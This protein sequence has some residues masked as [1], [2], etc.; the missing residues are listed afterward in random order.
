MRRKKH[1]LN[2]AGLVSIGFL[3]ILLT[4]ALLLMLPAS[5]GSGCWTNPLT[6]LFTATS[7]TCVTGLLL[8][9]NWIYWSFFGQAV[10][11][12]MIQVGGLG[13][14]TIMILISLLIKRKI[15]FSQ[16]VTVVSALNLKDLS[17][18]IPVLRLALR[19]TFWFELVGT[20][21]FAIR[22]VPRFGWAGGLWRSLFTSV[23][24]FCNAGF[25]LMGASGPF[26]SMTEYA[27]DPYLCLLIM[28]LTVIPGLGFFVWEDVARNRRW[29]RLSLYSRLVLS[30][31][32][33]LILQ[34]TVFFALAEWSNPETIGGMSLGKKLLASLF[35]SVI[36]RTTGFAAIDQAALTEGSKIVS[37][38]FM[39]VGGASGSTA[40]GVKVVTIVVL[41]RSLWSGLTGKRELVI[42]GHKISHQKVVDAMNLVLMVVLLMVF[43]SIFLTMVEGIPYTDALYESAAALG[44]TGLGMGITP[45]LSGLSRLWIMCMMFV[46]RVGVLSISLSFVSRRKGRGQLGYPEGWVMIG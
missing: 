5:S 18:V 7:A 31:S 33:G 40:G 21:L 42:G 26:T 10:I 22:F 36:L 16:R 28:V 4:G 8:V 29:K 27:T 1:R 25:D 41:F 14:V 9:D 38:L 23:S 11:L 6:A 44:T 24:T 34:G 35:Q 13:L 30:A 45:T 2:P 32:G 37:V 12:C 19:G 43:T 46:G 20:V 15:S 17:G 39:L 3:V